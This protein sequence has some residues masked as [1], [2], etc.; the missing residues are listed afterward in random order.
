[1]TGRNWLAG[2]EQLRRNQVAEHGEAGATF[3]RRL[4]EVIR[5]CEAHWQITV[6]EA[7]PELS[8]NFVAK[9]KRA[10]GTPAVLKVSRPGALARETAALRLWNGRGACR[11][12]ESEVERGWLLLEHLLPGTELRVMKDDEEA[13]RI[14][15][16][17]MPRLWIPAPPDHGL[18]TLEER[19][20]AFQDLRS[21]FGGG[22][23]PFPQRLVVEAERVFAYFPA[24]VAPKVLHG[25]FHHYNLLLAQ[26]RPGADAA[27]WVVIDPHG[28]VGDP[29]YE[30]GAFIYNPG[31]HLD[32]LAA[33]D[34]KSRIERR[35][36]IL[37]EELG[38]ERERVRGWCLAQ[39]VLSSWWTYQEGRAPDEGTLTVA[40]ILD[41]LGPG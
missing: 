21:E 33:P 34:P 24:G 28:A 4:P 31:G 38:W 1:V 16:R 15:A 26:G 18:E 8:Y 32:P 17:A 41:G 30:V 29:G 27:E 14:A 3:L 7:F 22:T 20:A 12:L 5:E 19:G 25:D 6:E 40:T 9:A 11:V 23:G 39:S 36:A 35:V 37:A 13:T 2:Q 10:D